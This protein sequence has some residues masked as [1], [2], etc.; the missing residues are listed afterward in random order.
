MM[1]VQRIP[2]FKS[3]LLAGKTAIR[4]ILVTAAKNSAEVSQQTIPADGSSRE[5]LAKSSCCERP[6][7][8]SSTANT[9]A[10]IACFNCGAGNSLLGYTDGLTNV[11]HNDFAN[12]P[13]WD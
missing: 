13:Y 11:A 7:C 12:R 5:N 3:C 2:M 6:V 10:P 8:F 9:S 1:I 4:G